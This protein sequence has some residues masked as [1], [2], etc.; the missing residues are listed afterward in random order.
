MF[1]RGY[2]PC[3][4][5]SIFV[6]TPQSHR[7]ARG[8]RHRDAGAPAGAAGA[9][10]QGLRRDHGLAGRVWRQELVT[11]KQNTHGDSYGFY[12]FIIYL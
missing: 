12:G 8:P 2:N 7:N 1:T 10:R 11:L 4:I 9:L 6:E 3:Y 5:P